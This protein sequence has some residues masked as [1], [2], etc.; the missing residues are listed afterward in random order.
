MHIN[1]RTTAQIPPKRASVNPIA[2][3]LTIS[4][5]VSI[6]VVFVENDV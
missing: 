5:L 4:V 2:L 3:D 6:V 1:T